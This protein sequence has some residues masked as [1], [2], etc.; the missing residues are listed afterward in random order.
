[1]ICARPTI[2]LRVQREGAVRRGLDGDQGLE[3][4]RLEA[5]RLSSNPFP[6]PAS[7]TV[8]TVRRVA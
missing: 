8:E 4:L 5:T 6:L 3:L 1:M 7:T 2:G